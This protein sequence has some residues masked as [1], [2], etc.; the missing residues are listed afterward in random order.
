MGWLNSDDV[1]YPWTIRTVLDIF[2]QFP[3]IEWLTTRCPSAINERGVMIRMPET[4]GF[5]RAS[6]RKGFNLTGAG[7]PADIFIQQESTFWRRSLW[8]KAGSKLDASL[9]YAGDFELWLRFFDY[10]ELYAVDVPLAG[11]RK[12]SDQK[13]SK[14]F[15]SYVIEAVR[16]LDTAGCEIP[17][18]L[19][20]NWQM[21]QRRNPSSVEALVLAGLADR[22]PIISYD[23]ASGSWAIK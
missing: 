1:Y 5:D 9:R 3:K 21:E 17:D 2:Q 10:A 7:W 19:V 8:E 23:W 16:C 14:A 22:A 6:F 18:P 4:C 13:T 15:A 20:M 12:H 11:F